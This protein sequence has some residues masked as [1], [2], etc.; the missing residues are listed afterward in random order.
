MA[1]K[2]IILNLPEVLYERIRQRAE[3]KQ[4]SIETE[5]IEVVISAVP[6]LDE[7][8]ADLAKAVSFLAFLDDKALERAAKNPMPKK[9]YA[10]LQSLHLKRQREGLDEAETK[11]LADLMKR[12]EQAFLV[13]THALEILRQRGHDISAFISR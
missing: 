7:L 6:V 11:L 4:H 2:S 13:R 8:P 5:L 10:K 12:Y 3:Q 9:S 1:T